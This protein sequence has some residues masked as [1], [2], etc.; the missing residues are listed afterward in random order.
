MSMEIITRRRI[1]GFL[2]AIPTVLACKSLLMR[3]AG[4]EEA[5]DEAALKKRFEVLSQN[6][7][8]DCSAKFEAS[9][10][11]M[12]PDARLQGSCCVPMDQARYRQQINGLRKYSEIAEV[13]P[14]RYDISAPLAHKAITTWS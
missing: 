1:F 3:R 2:V 7:N 5:D 4:A 14:D 10:A 13:P 6:T 9:I 11:T 12:S 8:V